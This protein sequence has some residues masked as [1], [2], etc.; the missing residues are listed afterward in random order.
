[1][2]PKGQLLTYQRLQRGHTGEVLFAHQFKREFHNPCISLYSLNLKIG[3]SECQ[4][5]HLLILQHEIIPIEI[6]YF[7]GDYYFE[8][9]RFFIAATDREI[10]NPILQMNR[11]RSLFHDFLKI[12]RTHLTVT[13]YVIFVHPEFHLYHAPQHEAL[14]FPGQVSR[15]I[16]NLHSVPHRLNAHHANIAEIFKQAHLPQSSHEIIPTYEYQ[17]VKK[18]IVCS[19][20][21]GFMEISHTGKSL[22]CIEC[23][24]VNKMEDATIRSIKEFH[25]LFPDRKIMIG[26]I[27]DWCDGLVS[28]GNIKRILSKNFRLI[29]KGK[30]S[31]Y[32][33]DNQV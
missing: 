9:N 10:N 13:P 3:N 23:K 6:K 7:P 18:G 22:I 33:V 29:N 26:S 15:F 17:Y 21:D 28:K 24:S 8:D 25:C 20:C 31:Y 30:Y 16:R 32:I 19:L 27:F 2:L 11:T 5:D 4:I 14:I 12:H 1:V